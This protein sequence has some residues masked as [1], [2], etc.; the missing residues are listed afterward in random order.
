MILLYSLCMEN[1]KNLKQHVPATQTFE[2][3]IQQPLRECL[4]G[5]KPMD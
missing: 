3:Q 1:L 4:G 5:Y 2:L